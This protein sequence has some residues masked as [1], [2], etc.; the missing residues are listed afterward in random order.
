MAVDGRSLNPD[1]AGAFAQGSQQANILKNQRL[2]GELTQQQIGQGQAEAERANQFNKLSGSVL[3]GQYDEGQNKQQANILKNQRLQGELTQQQIGQGQAEAERANQFNKLAGS[4]LSGQY[5][6]GQNKQQAINDLI[7]NNPEKAKGILESLG[8]NNQQNAD[9]ASSWAYTLEN[10]PVELRGN[11]IQQ[12]IDKLTAEGRDPSDTASFLNMSP[13]DQNKVA[14]VIQMA[15]L[16][17]KERMAS[18]GGGNLPAETAGFNDLIKDMSPEQQKNAK[19]IKAG[20][21]GRAMSNALITAIAD[22]NVTSLAEAKAQIAES[23]EFAKKTG[24]SRA[25]A[26]DEGFASIAKISTGIGNIDAAIAAVGKGAGVGAIEKKFPS[27]KAASVELDN[28]RG[29]M[30]L[31]IIGATT[32]GALSESELEFAKEVALP[33]GLNGPELIEY[34]TIKKSGQEKLRAYYNEQIQFIDQG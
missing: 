5:D 29:R 18:Q 28:I 34:L 25:K 13:E 2:Q 7:R 1:Y 6:E 26:I 24:S 16:S 23:E 14:S 12:R 19:L 10:T 32:F 31:D 3:S 33:T 30:A 20:L 27:L 15:A 22:G 11:L 21:K 8:I 9:E 17:T 4:V